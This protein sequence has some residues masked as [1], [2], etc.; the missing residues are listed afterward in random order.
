MKEVKIFS[1]ESSE[2][3]RSLLF[4]KLTKINL[5]GLKSEIYE[6]SKI[7]P[8]AV[9]LFEICENHIEKIIDDF[10]APFVIEEITRCEKKLKGNTSKER[11]ISF[12]VDKNG[13]LSEKCLS[14]FKKYDSKLFYIKKIIEN[15]IHSLSLFFFRLKKDYSLFSNVFSDNYQKLEKLKFNLSDRHNFMGGSILLTFSDG[16]KIIYK[17]KSGMT[18]LLFL[19]IVELLKLNKNIS[20]NQP[21]VIDCKLYSWHKFVKKSHYISEKSLQ[22]FYKHV[23][24]ILALCDALNYMDGHSENCICTKNKQLIVIDTETFFTNLSYFKEKTKKFYKLEFTGLIQKIKKNEHYLSAIQNQESNSYFPFMP[25]IKN[26]LTDRISFSYRQIKKNKNNHAFPCMKKIDLKKYKIDIEVGMR[27]GYQAIL[28]HH[29]EILNIVFQNASYLRCRHLARHTLYYTWILYR[30]LHPKNKKYEEFLSN[31][32]KK[33]PEE[34][35]KYE[36]NFLKYANIPVCYHDI[37]KKDL[38]GYFDKIIV[39][40]YFENTAFFWLEK[41]LQD[42]SKPEFIESRIKEMKRLI[43]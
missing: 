42:I 18:D 39:K 8:L 9:D 24:C 40:D 31:S 7:I 28:L 2:K 32:L 27:L 11:Y 6:I 5:D 13:Y 17:P 38:M 25:Y 34:M 41:K 29:Q 4:F 36:S 1:V 15:E 19:Q 26:D 12:F 35:Q 23:G 10:F 33:L 37:L 3:L 21:K 22:S 30:F 16:N 43:L 20:F 14:L